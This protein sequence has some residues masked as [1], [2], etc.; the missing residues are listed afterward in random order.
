MSLYLNLLREMLVIVSSGMHGTFSFFLSFNLY[1]T[2]FPFLSL[3]FPRPPWLPP[4]Y[5]L[6]SAHLILSSLSYPPLHHSTVQLFGQVNHITSHQSNLISSNLISYTRNRTGIVFIFAFLLPFPSLPSPSL[7]P[8]HFH[9]H[10]FFFS[11][12]DFT[13][14]LFGADSNWLDLTCTD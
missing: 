6:C 5:A 1:T 3:P 2:S 10:K 4:S 12:T 9:F 13:D 8:I 11:L 14:P 7:K